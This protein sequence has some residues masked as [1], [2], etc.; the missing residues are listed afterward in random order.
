MKNQIDGS[1][2]NVKVIQLFFFYSWRANY[3]ANIKYSLQKKTNVISDLFPARKRKTDM[4][5]KK[6]L[7]EVGIYSSMP[8]T[9]KVQIKGRETGSTI[10]KFCY[11]GEKVQK[12]PKPDRTVKK[13]L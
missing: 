3:L 4:R 1:E 7:L 13:T 12:W 8:L 11:A 5:P 6:S 9:S 2:K 10:Y